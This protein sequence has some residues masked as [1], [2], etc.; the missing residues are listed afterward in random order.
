[1]QSCLIFYL[2]NTMLWSALNYYWLAPSKESL[3][4]LIAVQLL[5]IKKINTVTF[6]PL[7]SR[8]QKY[9]KIENK[10]REKLLRKTGEWGKGGKHFHTPQGAP[11]T[12]NLNFCFLSF[13]CATYKK[14]EGMRDGGN[15]FLYFLILYLCTNKSVLKFN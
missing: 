10:F 8:T 12:L 6:R 9:T 3:T 4:N 5:S 2:V 15:I 14:W 11:A 13:F 7:Y 1:M